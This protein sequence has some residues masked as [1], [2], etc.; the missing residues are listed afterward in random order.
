MSW[1]SRV[2]RNKKRHFTLHIKIIIVKMINRMLFENFMKIFEIKKCKRFI[3]NCILRCFNC[4]KYEHIKKHCRIVVVCEK[5]V[6][7][8]HISE[9]DSSIIEKYKMCE[10][11]E[12][13]E[14]IAWSS[15]CKMRRKKKQKTKHAR[16]IWMRLYFVNESQIVLNVFR[17]VI[18]SS[19]KLFTIS[20]TNSRIVCSK[21]KM[22]KIKKKRNER[23]KSN[24]AFEFSL[25]SRRIESKNNITSFRDKNLWA[26]NTIMNSKNM[27]KALH[28]NS[29]NRFKFANK[30]FVNVNASI[31]INQMIDFDFLWKTQTL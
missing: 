22:I 6:M 24:I 26:N 14:H 12:N 23:L 20:I 5:C 17:F 15:K 2:I 18:N 25:I 9:C 27:K 1:S 11:C 16:Q 28:R 21:W 31:V 7:K 19:I 4:Q 13:R 30:S 8:H 3:K 10:T 29:M